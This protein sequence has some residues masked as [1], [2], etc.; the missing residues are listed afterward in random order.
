ML[1]QANWEAYTAEEV[2]ELPHGH[3]IPYP[4]AVEPDG[5]VTTLPGFRNFPDSKGSVLGA[6]M[7]VR[8]P[9]SLMRR[10]DPAARAGA[11]PNSSFRACHAR[12]GAKVRAQGLRKLR[13]D[14]TPQRQQ[15]Q[16]LKLL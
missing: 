15:Q 4:I 14:V 13:D 11:Q 7:K 9:T 2:Q 5:F 6:I 12:A 8:A 16:R 3:L 10:A 1:V